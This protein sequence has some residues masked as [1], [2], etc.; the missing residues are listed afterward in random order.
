[1]SGSNCCFLTC[2]QISQGAGQVVWHSH[3]LMNFPQF[4]V[5]HTVKVF[6][7]VNKAEINIFLELFCF[8][9]IDCML[10]IWSLVPVPFLEHLEV[11]GS[12]I[13]EAWIHAI[14]M[15]IT[16]LL[17]AADKYK[18]CWLFWTN[19]PRERLVPLNKLWMRSNKDKLYCVSREL[20]DSSN[21]AVLLEWGIFGSSEPIM[22]DW[23]G[24]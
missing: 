2:I 14:L 17:Q 16:I 19:I 8:F 22:L 23:A 7:V 15:Y 10:A 5:I 11:L 1:M 18:N 9:M 3:L 24:C 6:G 4:V 12:C 21:N 13:V 20:P